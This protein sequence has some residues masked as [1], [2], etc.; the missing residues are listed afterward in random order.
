MKYMMCVNCVLCIQSVQEMSQSLNP[1]THHHC[2]VLKEWNE[3]TQ[4]FEE[5]PV[6]N[7]FRNSL[8]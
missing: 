5:M 1:G 8:K 3:F 2:L 6:R 4:G 7:N